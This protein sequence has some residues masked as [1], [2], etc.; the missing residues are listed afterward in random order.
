MKKIFLTTL[1]SIILFGATAE[2]VEQYLSV[3]NSEE[4]LIA[5]EAGFNS[6]QNALNKKSEENRNYDMQMLSVRFKEKLASELSEDEMK[7]VLENYNSMVYLQFA[8]ATAEQEQV[9][10][11]TLDAYIQKLKADESAH[12][13]L[14]RIEE[15]GKHIYKKEYLSDYFDALIA[16]LY[17]KSS[18]DQKGYSDFLKKTKKGYMEMMQSEGQKQLI[19]ALRDFSTEELEALLKVV[20]RP[21]V[22]HETKAV[23]K[24]MAY[25]LQEYFKS[26][27]S[28]FD[29]SQHQMHSP[30]EGN[31][32]HL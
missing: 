17:G 9:D 12:D 16:P 1:L 30:D 24:S 8:S 11:D 23:Y 4:Q 25:A 20:K 21:S 29:P 28:R 7:E 10:A 3:S 2:Q 22:D 26:L 14:L 5:L 13:R 32:S 18:Q 6:M 31:T 19:Y 27:A 15:I